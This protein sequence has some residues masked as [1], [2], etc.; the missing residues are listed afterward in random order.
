MRN[1]TLKPLF[2]KVSALL[3]FII[4][5]LVYFSPVLDNKKLKANDTTVFAGASREIVDFREEYRSEPLW[6]NS[7]FSGMPAYMIS[8][9]YPGNLIKHLYNFLKKP[10]IPVAP[11]LLTML[12]FY[13]LLLAYRVDPWLAIAGAIAYGLSSYFFI[14]LSAGHNTKAMALSFI[15]P[16]LG[17]IVFAYRRNM[18]YGALLTAI[19]LSLEII[20][21]H[22]QITYY[23][24][25][26]LLAFGVAE[27]VYSYKSD[28]LKRFFKT[29][30]LL[31]G[32]GIIAIIVNFA[33]LYTTYEYGKFSIRGES[34]LSASQE[35][36]SSGVD[37]SY[38]TYWSYG[39][40]E[41]LSLLIPNIK[42]GASKPFDRDSETVKAL[43]QNG[44]S[45]YA[46]Q[47]LQYWGN[48]PGTS[49]PVYTGAIVFLLFIM[50]LVLVK[51]RDKWWIVVITAIAIMLA[52]G[53]NFMFFTNLFMDFLPGYSK[54]RAVTTILVIVQL[55]MPLLGIIALDR[56]LKGEYSKQELLKAL[57]IGGGITAGILLIFL[58]IPGL[59]GSF[60]SGNEM[61][62]PD[63]LKAALKTDRME[64]LRMDIL[65]SLF[66]VISA[67]T[68]IYFAAIKKLR[69]GLVII[70]L[71]S[72][73]VIDM[74]P[75]DK[76]YL[77]NNNFVRKAEVTKDLQPTAADKFILED[78]S[79]YRVLNLTVSPFN[80]GTTSYNHNSI[81]GYHGAKIRRYQDLIEKSIVPEIG[82]LTEKLQ[83]VNSIDQLG[84]VFSGL[85]AMNM[86]N[87]K[88]IIINPESQPLINN[89]A[90]G[91]CWFVE[92]VKIVPDADTELASVNNFDPAMEAI[93][94]S[95]FAGM[96]AGLEP[97]VDSTAS[98]LLTSSKSNE[99]VYKFNI[100]RDQLAVF[101]EIYYPKGWNAY[102]DG[103]MKEYFRA[104][105]ILRAMVLP[106][107]DH[108]L[109]FRFEPESYR[110]GNEIS[111]AGSIILILLSIMGLIYAIKK[112]GKVE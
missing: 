91:N 75:V 19:V 86:L 102:I 64:M 35:D 47:F 77:N 34:E 74:W 28:N 96:V 99:L 55:C 59:A 12:G 49:G 100:S 4:V 33:S 21:N 1:I 27:L 92:S 51:D 45:Q 89:R 83:S 104:N 112:R 52:W 14:L 18:I 68:I 9:Q 103:E 69:Y 58:L 3:V 57:K 53:K 48:Q 108:E 20:S 11:I 37:R 5:T 39:V 7:M 56:I 71:T 106:E 66:F 95:R 10:G 25:M 105:Y 80:D 70:L 109:V 43:R 54:F 111:L 84:E 79:E 94:D 82:I 17:S 30:L 88:Y 41:T 73:V 72:L 81:G 101:S 8:V 2:S 93:V 15:A 16:L 6:T 90:L 26:I 44:A 13:L 23:A 107:G 24:F 32:A 98:I 63:W 29:T 36:K 42:G 76:R 62:F 60:I 87:T 67:G 46:N 65:R 50:G 110:I 78:A 97:G 38:A 40:D 61:Q 31:V 85:N 22:L